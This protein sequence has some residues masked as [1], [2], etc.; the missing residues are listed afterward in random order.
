MERAYIC[1]D[2]KSFFASVECVQR[3]LDPFEINLV[4][5]DPSRG[6]GAICL[7][8]TPHMKQLGVK[9]RCR[10]FEIP[11]GIEYITALPRMS[12]YMEYAARIYKVLLKYVAKEDIHVYSIDESFLDVTS[13]L[14]LYEMTVY[15]LAEVIT[16]DIF[17]TTGITATAGMGPNLYLAKVALDI[18]SKTSPNGMGYLDE[19]LYKQKLWHHQPITDFWQVGRGIARRLAKYG[20]TDM[21]GVAQ[22]P[23]YLLEKEFGINGKYLYDHAWG[24]EPVK[25]SEIRQYKS[26]ARSVSNSQIL[27]EDYTTD[28]ALLI[29]KEMVDTNVLRLVKN[30]L[31]TDR[32]GLYIGYSKNV[33]KPTSVMTKISNRTNSGRILREEFVRLYQRSVKRGVPIRQIAIRFQDVRDEVYEMYDLFTDTEEVEKEKKMQTAVLKIKE[34]YGKNA[35]LKGMNLEEKATARL[36]NRLIGGHN[37]K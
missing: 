31:V 25:I 10:I 37:A 7:A 9:N 3:G 13:Y 36:R 30:Q 33:E 15:E 4:V 12:L 18:L 16:D 14:K 8:V 17:Q 35:I 26:K 6:N 24:I 22:C 5:A 2:L 11:K 20:I 21:Y 34:R 29:V 19:D 23:Y 28:Q 27:F 1:V 32:I